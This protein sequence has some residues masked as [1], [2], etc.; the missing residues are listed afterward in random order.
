MAR[1]KWLAARETELLPVPYFHVV[2]TLP[3]KIGGLALQNPAEIYRLRI[4][5]H[6]RSDA[7]TSEVLRQQRTGSAETDD[8]DLGLREN[9]LAGIAEKT[10]LASIPGAPAR[11][12]RPSRRCQ[13]AEA[14][15]DDRGAG[16]F[17][18]A[19]ARQP[20]IPGD[21]I[22]RGHQPADGHAP[23]EVQKSRIAPLV[24]LQIVAGKSDA[25]RPAVIMDSKIDEPFFPACADTLGYEFRLQPPVARFPGT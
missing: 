15:A 12:A 14:S 18:A 1:A 5:K 22:F 13:D 23:V 10:R 9:V 16:Q 8:S 17:D 3:Q 2:F 25:I 7:E 20:D 24:R 4:D 6:K 19:L 21:R 11:G